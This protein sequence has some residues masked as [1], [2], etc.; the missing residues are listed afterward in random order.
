MKHLFKV[1]FALAIIVIL[2]IIL[3]KSKIIEKYGGHGW[4]ANGWGAHGAW[5]YGRRRR[6]SRKTNGLNY[7]AL[8]YQPAD[9]IC[10]DSL[11]NLTYCLTPNLLRPYFYY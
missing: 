5:G 10:Y 11:G 8:Y 9:N 7:N 6:W 4:R 3:K 2:Y 1:L